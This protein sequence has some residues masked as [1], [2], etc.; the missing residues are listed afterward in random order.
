MN[1]TCQCPDGNQETA[2]HDDKEE[3]CCKRVC[4][5]PSERGA[6]LC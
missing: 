4:R 6:P 2:T 3:H 1:G 5:N